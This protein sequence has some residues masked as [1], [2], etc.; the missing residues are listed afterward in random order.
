MGTE[1]NLPA[2]LQDEYP[3]TWLM[4]AQERMALV[5]L[6][7]FVKPPVALEIGTHCGGSLQ[8]IAPRARSVYSL[9]LN[10]QV[11]EWLGGRFPNVTFRTGDSRTVLPALL[12]EIEA[13]G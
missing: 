2:F 11:P 1:V 5:Q 3:I 9:D 8:V 7:E 10:P 6:L 12:R 13:K 4:T